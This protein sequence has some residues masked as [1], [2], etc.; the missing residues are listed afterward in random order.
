MKSMR[1]VIEGRTRNTD[2]QHE[3]RKLRVNFISRP[4]KIASADIS[5][6]VYIFELLL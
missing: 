4:P 6:M 3:D 1:P 2:R 5:V